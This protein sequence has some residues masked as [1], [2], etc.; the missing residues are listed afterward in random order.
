MFQN[1]PNHNHR[2]TPVI[3]NC[4][5]PVVMAEYEMNK[6]LQ[7]FIERLEKVACQEVA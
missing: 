3:G 6:Y 5:L 4:L 1:N 7:V 2:F